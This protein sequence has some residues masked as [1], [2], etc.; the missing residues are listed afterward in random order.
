MLERERLRNILCL[1]LPI[2]GGMLSQSLLNLVDAAMV[3]H[4]G[5]KSL[6]GVGIGS[7]ANFVA[8][9]LVMGLGAG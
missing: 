5:E 9:S 2:I 4:L 7:Y 1:G 8:I 3:G 6:A